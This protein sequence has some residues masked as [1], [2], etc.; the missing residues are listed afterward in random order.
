[1]S[2]P[3]GT[4]IAFDARLKRGAF[5][6]NAA[7]ETDGGITALFGP[8]GSGKTTILHLIAGLVRPNQGRIALGSRVLTDTASSTFVPK[9]QR[10]IGLVFQDA[11]LFPHL[12]VEHNLRFG[13]WFS[14]A[15]ARQLPI[16][17]VVG[18]LGIGHLL[19]RRPPGLSGG[20][21]QRVALARALLAAPELLLLDEPLAGLD[22]GRQQE[23]LPLIELVRDEFLVPILYVTHSA[24]EVRRLANNVIRLDAG[25]VVAA[26]I[27]GEVLR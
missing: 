25:S 2:N 11:Q 27:P 17:A 19:K 26:G 8:S 21:R 6:L 13:R 23:I 14:K 12:S 4:R 22:A 7:F 10:H 20:E 15:G 9:H 18:A 5:E 16:D 1:M 3:A 24:D